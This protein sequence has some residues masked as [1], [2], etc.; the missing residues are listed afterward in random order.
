MTTA[1]A[2]ATGIVI[3]VATGT[4]TGVA[5]TGAAALMTDLG[6]RQPAPRTA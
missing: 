4:V 1:T 2:T 6:V 5:P 3:A